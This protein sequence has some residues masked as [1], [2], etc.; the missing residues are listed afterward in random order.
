MVIYVLTIPTIY[1]VFGMKPKTVVK[2]NIFNISGMRVMRV[3]HFYY[4]FFV[5]Y[6]CECMVYY[7]NCKEDNYTEVIQND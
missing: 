5:F 3:P 4:A 6:K 1:L 7:N 2:N